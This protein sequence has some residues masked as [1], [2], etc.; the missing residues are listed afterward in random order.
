MGNSLPQSGNGGICVPT[1]PAIAPL[2]LASDYRDYYGRQH[3]MLVEKIDPVIAAGCYMPR[4]Y[5]AP[6]SAEEVAGVP[7]NGYLEYVLELPAGG[8]ILGFLHTTLSGLVDESIPVSG[9]RFQISDVTRNYRFF[10]KPV[11]EAWLLND[12]LGT[13]DTQFNN[14]WVLNPA[15]RLLAAPYPIAPPGQFKVE[16]WETTGSLNTY[17]QIS[18]VV[19]VPPGGTNGGK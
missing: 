16:F 15:P 19:A 4:I 10:G 12:Q 1:T 6:S 17:V 14:E 5:H 9:F 8:F 11:P 3:E 2:R 7:G 13:D 18:L